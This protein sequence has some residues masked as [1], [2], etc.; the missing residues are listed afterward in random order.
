MVVQFF[1]VRDDTDVNLGGDLLALSRM[2]VKLLLTQ[3]NNKRCNDD[4]KDSDE[5]DNNNNSSG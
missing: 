3:D 5:E 4:H 1:L 2:E